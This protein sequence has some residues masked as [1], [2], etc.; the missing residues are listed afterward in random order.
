MIYKDEHERRD[1]VV[2]NFTCFTGMRVEDIHNAK[3][4]NFTFN[5]ADQTNPRRLVAVLDQTKNDKKGNGPASGRTFMLPCL[6]MPTDPANRKKW[7]KT[8]LANPEAPCLDP[9]PFNIVYNYLKDCPLPDDNSKEAPLS[10]IRALSSRGDPRTIARGPLSYSEI[11][12]IPQRVNLRL[13]E[14]NQITKATGKVGRMTFTSR[15]MNDTKVGGEVTAV[16]TKHKDPKT[17]LGYVDADQS[18][19][20]AAALEI[21]KAVKNSTNQNRLAGVDLTPTHS[22]S[23]V[24]KR[25]WQEMQEEETVKDENKND[26]NNMIKITK[27]V[28]QSSTT[29]VVTTSECGMKTT[30]VNLTFNF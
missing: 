27:N 20:M 12:K 10:F 16:A 29:S 13:S 1:L 26:N 14:E 23:N 9:C 18:L 11:M 8:L 15:A 25:S 24:L 2:I 22:D 19:L 28:E 30:T 21:G 4:T 3:S 17:M 7:C 5:A 6:C